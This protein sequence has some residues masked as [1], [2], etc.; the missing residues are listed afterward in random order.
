[1]M[2]IIHIYFIYCLL[3]PTTS[4]LIEKIHCT[5]YWMA[6]RIDQI[7]QMNLVHPVGQKSSAACQKHQ[8]LYE[9]SFVSI[10]EN[11]TNRLYSSFQ[12]A[13]MR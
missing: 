13:R 6:R 4:L 12:E 8:V 5:W 1:M 9:D 3:D 2:S 11:V 10:G 7:L